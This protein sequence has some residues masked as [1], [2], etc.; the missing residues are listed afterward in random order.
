M[1]CTLVDKGGNFIVT[2]KSP[3]GPWSNP[4][5]IPQIN[6]IDPSLFFDADDADKAYIVYNSVAPN[7]KP[8]YNGHRT[9]RIYEFDTDSL[10]VVGKEHILINGGTDVSKKP[11]WIE[12]P[13]IF[14][15][16]V[17]IS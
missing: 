16:M 9:I 11:V 4:V 6:G 15:K 7:N 3:Q 10:K 13:H 12:G 17:F 1:T 8:L 5:W 14:K 2:S